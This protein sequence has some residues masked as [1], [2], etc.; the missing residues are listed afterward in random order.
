MRRTYCPT[1]VG[2]ATTARAISRCLN[3]QS[4]CWRSTSRILRMVNV[5]YAMWPLDEIVEHATV[6]PRRCIK[7][8]LSSFV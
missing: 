8:L 5:G 4:K 3:P 1:V 7:E 2:E 6:D